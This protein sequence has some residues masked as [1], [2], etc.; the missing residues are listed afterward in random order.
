MLNR[1]SGLQQSAQLPTGQLPPRTIAIQDIF[2]LETA[3]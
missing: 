3:T 2:H 1:V